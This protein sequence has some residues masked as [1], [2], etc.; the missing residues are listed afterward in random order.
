MSGVPISE[1]GP[2]GEPYQVQRLSGGQKIYRCP[3]CDHEIAVGTS[4]VVAW[5]EEGSGLWVRGVQARRHWHTNCW[6]RKLRPG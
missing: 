2:G 5:P 4:H 6:N 3:G 1:T